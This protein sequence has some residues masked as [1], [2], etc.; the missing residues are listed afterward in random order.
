MAFWDQSCAARFGFSTF[1]LVVLN[2]DFSVSSE[3]QL[4]YV[5][6][7]ENHPIGNGNDNV[8]S[9]TTEKP[10]FLNISILTKALSE[11]KTCHSVSLGLESLPNLAIVAMNKNCGRST[12]SSLELVSRRKL[13]S[14]EMTSKRF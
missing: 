11:K 12:D 6:E 3:T 13:V 2:V 5:V 1:K 8:S 7:A 4:D 10:F 14:A 9:V